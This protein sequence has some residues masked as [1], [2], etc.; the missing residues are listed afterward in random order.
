MAEK[1]K[2]E[3]AS[4]LQGIERVLEINGQ[5]IPGQEK[6]DV[7]KLLTSGPVEMV[8]AR[9]SREETFVTQMQELSSKLE[10]LGQER[11]GLKGEN[12]RL[13]HRISYLEEVRH[14]EELA[15]EEDAQQQL[16]PKEKYGN[17]GASKTC[18]SQ[19]P[20]ESQSLYRTEI[21]VQVPVG[22]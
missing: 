19:Q 11:D 8:V 20:S 2:T 4:M 5:L 3:I 6:V 10:R 15:E 13:K 16:T 9:Q 22:T 21:R 17:R 18:Q 14:D 7:G 12:L 1:M